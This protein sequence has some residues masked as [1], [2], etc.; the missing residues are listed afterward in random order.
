MLIRSW[1]SLV[2]R[3]V[4]ALLLG[5]FALAMPAGTLLALVIL[6]G[7]YAIADGVIAFVSGVRLARHH[8]RWWPFVVEG[9]LGVAAGI[10]AFLWPQI[11]AV[12][13]VFLIAV[14]AL[15]TGIME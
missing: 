15:A 10:V 12:A 3:G 8:A 7:V 13:L 5:I 2:T 11:T 1:W 9:L 6:F 14:W 4:I